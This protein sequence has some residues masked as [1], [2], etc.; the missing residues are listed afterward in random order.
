MN[1]A[2]LFHRR[3]SIPRTSVVM[4]KTTPSFRV[5]VFHGTVANSSS[6]KPKG[7]LPKNKHE[8]NTVFLQINPWYA[9][10]WLQSPKLMDNCFVDYPK[11]AIGE[12]FQND[13]KDDLLRIQNKFKD[14]LDR[15]RSIEEITN[16]FLSDYNSGTLHIL[17]QRIG[18]L[19]LHIVHIK[20]LL[21]LSFLLFVHIILHTPKEVYH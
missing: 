17:S 1:A 12:H 20:Y 6:S 21:L 13:L 19:C 9:A 15:K 11:I 3:V 7:K 18:C 10:H 8:D 4:K 14:H 5:L 2:H 16:A